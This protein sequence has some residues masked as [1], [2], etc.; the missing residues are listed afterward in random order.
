MNEAECSNGPVLASMQQGHAAASVDD[1]ATMTEAKIKA[2]R[3]MYADNAPITEIAQAL[4]VGRMSVS[5]ALSKVQLADQD[6]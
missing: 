6:H 3:T 4:G 5:R 2:A 1:P